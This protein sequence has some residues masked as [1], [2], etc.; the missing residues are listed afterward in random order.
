MLGQQ[1]FEMVNQKMDRG[2][3]DRVRESSIKES[4]HFYEKTFIQKITND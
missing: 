1:K 2:T 3:I 4:Q